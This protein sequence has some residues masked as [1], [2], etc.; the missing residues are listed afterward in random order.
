[1]RRRHKS[2]RVSVYELLKKRRDG[3]LR[4]DEILPV[5]DQ[6]PYHADLYLSKEF[7]E[8]PS[9]AGFRETRM[10]FPIGQLA[11][12]RKTTKQGHYHIHDFGVGWGIHRD[13]KAPKGVVGHTLHSF[14]DMPSVTI[15]GTALAG[16][17]SYG[18]YR[19]VKDLLSKRKAL[20]ELRKV[21]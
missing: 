21:K 19:L 8:H 11:N 7:M 17:S 4:W 20:K 5:V 1:M 14:V 10:A 12:W 3:R 16:L 18:V 13:K 6:M 2:P 15:A 9:A